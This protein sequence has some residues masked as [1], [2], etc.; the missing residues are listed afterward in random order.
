[1]RWEKRNDLGFFSGK[2]KIRDQKLKGVHCSTSS[3]GGLVTEEG[4]AVGRGS[5]SEHRWENYPWREGKPV[6]HRECPQEEDGR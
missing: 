6:F 4:R 2:G 3:L 1:M 5:E